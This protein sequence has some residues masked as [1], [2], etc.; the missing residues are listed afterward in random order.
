MALI[1]LFTLVPQVPAQAVDENSIYQVTDLQ[2]L[3]K[4]LATITDDKTIQL[5][6]DIN[7][8]EIAHKDVAFKDG[9]GWT[10]L[11]FT[12]RN[13]IDLNGHTL[14]IYLENENAD[15]D[16][17]FHIASTGNVLFKNGNITFVP[18]TPL[19]SN[20]G[21]YNEGCM[22]FQNVN[23]YLQD[24]PIGVHTA[25][26]GSLHFIDSTFLPTLP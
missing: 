16:M 23:V 12:K 8:S 20:I 2:D 14:Y 5:T 13:V 7:A 18:K 26:H 4:T 10:I 15:R 11:R 3:D 1:F 22:M 25:A 24:F 9:K 19:N 21:I 17:V 6:Q